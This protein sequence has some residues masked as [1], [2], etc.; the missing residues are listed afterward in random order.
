MNE[1]TCVG[2]LLA[3]DEPAPAGGPSSPEFLN[4]IYEYEQLIR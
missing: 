1:V 4:I 3:L 2:L